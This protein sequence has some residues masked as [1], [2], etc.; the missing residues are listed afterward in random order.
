MSPES[1]VNRFDHV[2]WLGGNGCSGKS[3][4]A[5]I[6]AQRFPFEIYHGDGWRKHIPRAKP[7][8]HPLMCQIRDGLYGKEDLFMSPPEQQVHGMTKLYRENFS[9]V[10]QDLEAMPEDQLVLVE[11]GQMLP[12]LVQTVAGP[13]HCIFLISANEFIRK[14]NLSR[15][16]ETKHYQDLPDP[17]LAL[18]NRIAAFDLLGKRVYDSAHKIGFRT[19]AVDGTTPPE[20]VAD[21]VATHFKLA[22]VENKSV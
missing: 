15:N 13:S 2:Y 6:L 5:N 4:I 9:F 10:L 17:Q 1:T 16:A 20:R 14:Y 8:N 3:T 11:G 18:E 22:G 19:F 21:L 12:E 7:D